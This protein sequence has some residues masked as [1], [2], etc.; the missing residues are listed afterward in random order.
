MTNVM[1]R[2]AL[3]FIMAMII[4]PSVQA[5]RITM[6]FAFNITNRD[7]IIHVND[8]DYNTTQANK[9]TFTG[10]EKK[11]VTAERNNSL[12]VLAF[13][14]EKMDNIKI[15]TSFSSQSYLI[16]L[17]QYDDRNKLLLGYTRGTWRNVD[18]KMDSLDTVKFLAKTFGDFTAFS[19]SFFYFIRLEYRDIV[20][21]NSIDFDGSLKLFVHNRGGR[22][23]TL[24]VVK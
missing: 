2:I 9:V 10:L 8:T 20:I 7:N 5:E 1:E 17:E 23:V 19:S 24:E 21:A 12:F 18:S 16:S 3:I 4:L 13:A 15:N 11:Y 22:N 14:G 6:N